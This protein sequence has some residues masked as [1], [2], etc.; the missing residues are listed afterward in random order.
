M[1]VSGRLTQKAWKDSTSGQA[2]NRYVVTALDIDLLT[3]N[4]DPILL[5]TTVVAAGTVQA[6][7]PDRQTTNG[8]VHSF[9]L[10]T[11]RAGTKTGRLWID[12]E[13]WTP[14]TEPSGLMVGGPVVATGHLGYS[15]RRGDDALACGTRTLSLRARQG[16][17]QPPEAVSSVR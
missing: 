12:V 10:A 16:L 13:H 6:V 14:S 7:Y 3:D 1:L 15:Q 4:T 5:P 11:G 9:R 17:T 2:R 8:V